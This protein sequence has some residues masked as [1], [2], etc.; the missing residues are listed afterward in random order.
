MGGY[1]R[2]ICGLVAA[3]A[4][5]ACAATVAGVGVEDGRSTS[6]TRDGGPWAETPSSPAI[7][8]TNEDGSAVTGRTVTDT[9]VTLAGVATAFDELMMRR[10]ECGRRPRTC[11]VGSLAVPGTALHRRLTELMDGRRV[12]GITASSRGAVRYRLDEVRIIAPDRALVT[13]CLTD[14]TVL[15]S[16]GA[17]FDD[18]IY[19]AITTWTMQH[20]DERW[21]WAEDHLS[22]WRR[23]EDL[24][25]FD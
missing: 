17:I 10:I 1:Q 16:G 19:S 8:D 13:T 14:D 2:M 18:G 21:L 11:D 20:V 12:A 3:L 15:V 9:A 24:C 5:S 25:G 23:G 6:T 22:T 4:G 7:G